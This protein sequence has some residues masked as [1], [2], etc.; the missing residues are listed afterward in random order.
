M[1]RLEP[2]SKCPRSHDEAEALTARAE[3]SELYGEAG[4]AEKE[5]KKSRGEQTQSSMMTKEGCQRMQLAINDPGGGDR[6]K[7]C[8]TARGVGYL[9][10]DMDR[11]RPAR[12]F[13]KH[14]YLLLVPR[15]SSFVA[16]R[17]VRFA[18]LALGASL[19][20]LSFSL[21]LSI[22]LCCFLIALLFSSLSLRVQSK[23]A[24][25]L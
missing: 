1:H 23:S 16:R 8:T 15:F 22:H 19:V 24:A 6:R 5:K 18:F 12:W 25:L 4:G 2:E 11:I 9:R 21:S 14:S 7:T 3:L 17:F 20:Y 13:C 10:H